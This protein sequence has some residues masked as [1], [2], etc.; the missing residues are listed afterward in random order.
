[1]VVP[2][3][4]ARHAVVRELVADRGP[5]RAAVVRAL[6]DLAEP[7]AALRSVDA[8][9]VGRRAFHVVD[10]PAREMRAGDLPALAL[11]VRGQYE[12]AL[13]RSDQHT[14]SAHRVSLR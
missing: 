13:A 2:L 12:P 4:R 7:A 14:N 6:H 9:R 10:L 8:V 5:R 1:P 11:A 3:V